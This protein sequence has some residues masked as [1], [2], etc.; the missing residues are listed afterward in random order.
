M[1]C[2]GQSFIY[3]IYIFILHPYKIYFREPIAANYDKYEEVNEHL[4]VL[5]LYKYTL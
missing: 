2:Y 5:H 1:N 3:H 4:L